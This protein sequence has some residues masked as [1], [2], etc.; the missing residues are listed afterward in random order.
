MHG[1]IV[2]PI[3]GRSLLSSYHF[4][5][6]HHFLFLFF[7]SSPVMLSSTRLLSLALLLVSALNAAAAPTPL[8][9]DGELVERQLPGFV[10][11]SS[12]TFIILTDFQKRG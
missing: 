7:L 10:F 3:A 5:H 4:H 8:T 6:F 2:N 11:C 1:C 12:P 9:Q